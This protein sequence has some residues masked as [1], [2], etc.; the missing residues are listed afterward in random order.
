L[1][2]CDG[3]VI[4]TL[5]LSLTSLVEAQAIEP[6]FKSKSGTLGILDD[7]GNLKP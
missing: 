3:P 2:L 5:R 4:R 7:V 1:K 6:G